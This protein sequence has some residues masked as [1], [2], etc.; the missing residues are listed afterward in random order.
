[1]LKSYNQ[2][3]CVRY[4]G[5]NAKIPFHPSGEFAST[6]NKSTWSTYQ[7]CK[8][9]IKSGKFDGL[10]FILSTDDDFFIIDVD[11]FKDPNTSLKSRKLASELIRDFNGTY[12]ETSTSG[13]G[14]HIICTTRKNPLD[15]DGRK[16]PTLGLEFYYARR[17]IIIT[18]NHNGYPFI[19]DQTEVLQKWRNEIFCTS[20]NPT[21]P[22]F[23]PLLTDDHA[24]L[25]KL[26]TNNKAWQL[27]HSSDTSLYNSNSE[28]D[29]AL[30]GYLY[31]LS[32][33]PEQTKRL[34]MAS[35][36]GERKKC[37]RQDYMQ[38]LSNKVVL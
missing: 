38:G 27:Y 2:W 30:F 1:M 36:R 16:S 28:A 7:E 6:T 31:R 37:Q 12:Q 29:M 35:K 18:G 8:T 26:E 23:R 33:N 4:T 24:V 9:A 17:A 11:T 14:K 21:Q 13:K 15:Q 20:H 19:T 32:G 3:A 5:K 34:F 22:F 25:L 10:S